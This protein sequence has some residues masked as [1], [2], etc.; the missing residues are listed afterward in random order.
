MECTV[1][2][3]LTC[4]LTHGRAGLWFQVPKE[5]LLCPL[6]PLLVLRQIFSCC[7]FSAHLKG[8]S[9]L[10][11]GQKVTDIHVEKVSWG[12]IKQLKNHRVTATDISFFF[13][14]DSKALP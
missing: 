5:I 12:Q 6:Y 7:P 1:N 9:F 2:R 3:N 10:Q 11:Q 4:K 8:S 14:L 13:T